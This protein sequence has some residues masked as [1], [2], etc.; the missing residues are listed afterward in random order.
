M[1][2]RSRMTSRTEI[3]RKAYWRLFRA[4]WRR[5]KLESLRLFIKLLPNES[6]RVF[7]L[8]LIAGALCGLAAVAFHLAIIKAE[9][10]LMGAALASKYAL[11]L[12]I[13][14]PIAG[15]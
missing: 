2:R 10:L 11:W 5:F 4:K 7:V 12:G 13:L 8:T 9:D 1:D 14:T 15:G 3:R 6:Q